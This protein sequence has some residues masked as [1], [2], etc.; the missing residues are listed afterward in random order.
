MRRATIY[1]GCII[2]WLAL[3]AQPAWAQDNDRKRTAPGLFS[4]KGTLKYYEDEV[5]ALF[6]KGRWE[7][8]KKL[9]DEGFRHYEQAVGL[10]RLMGTY[11]LHYNKPDR[12]R[13]YL[14]RALRDDNKDQ[15]TLHML[16]KI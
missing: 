16:M 1:I 11:W 6:K 4:T 7:E 12:A 8:G 13:Y 10:N 15:L 9:L 5:N 3:L 14:I 2:A